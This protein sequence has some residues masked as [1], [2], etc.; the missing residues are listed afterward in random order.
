M[1]PAAIV[2]AA[3]GSR[4]MDTGNK[5]LMPLGAG[6]IVAAVVDTVVAAGFDPVVAVT[7]YDEGAVRA[8]LE[9]CQVQFAANPHWERGLS[10]SLRAGLAALP[11]EADGTLVALGDMPLL[12]VGTLRRLKETFE[13]AGGERIVYP[14]YEGRQGNPVLFPRRLFPALL[15][16]EGDLG[17]KQIMQTDKEEALA[18]AV[19][20]QEVLMDCD[21]DDDY[22]TILGILKD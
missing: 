12:K 13:Q 1:Q 6:T 8:A 17:G 15:A 19:D 9:G 16:L 22:H 5:L 3:G 14:A 10:S 18:L 21:T 20:S 2:L 11:P 4:R 7:G